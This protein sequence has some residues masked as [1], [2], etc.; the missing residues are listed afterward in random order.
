M[1]DLSSAVTERTVTVDL[2]TRCAA[3]PAAVWRTLV[4]DID[5]WWGDPYVSSSER[6]S[7]TL[8]ARVGG[9]LLEDWGEGNGTVWGTVRTVRQPSRLEFDGT[10]MMVGALCGTVAITIEP[11]DTGSS[12]VRL[13]QQAFGA[14]SDETLAAWSNGWT[15][16]LDALSD[17]TE[18][19]E[20]DPT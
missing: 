19:Q 16:L 9:L 10:F 13:T 8:D 1:T 2:E 14:I 11:I 6:Q 7:L 18:R 3:P 20:Q 5:S 17:A 4:D 15:D 12:Q